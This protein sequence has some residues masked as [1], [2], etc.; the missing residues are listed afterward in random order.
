MRLYNFF[1]K[2]TFPKVKVKKAKKGKMCAS[3]YLDSHFHAPV[4]EQLRAQEGDRTEPTRYQ[5][6]IFKIQVLLFLAP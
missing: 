4:I 1:L 3:L 6:R 2:G 5:Q